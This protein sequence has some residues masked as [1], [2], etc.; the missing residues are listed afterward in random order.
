MLL[1][2]NKKK[3]SLFLWLNFFISLLISLFLIKPAFAFDV[4]SAP[5]VEAEVVASKVA[6]VAKLTQQIRYLEQALKTLTNA[7]YQWSMVQ[8]TINELGNAINQANTLAYNA[9]NLDARFK[10]IYP[11]YQSPKN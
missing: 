2:K 1:N 7:P 5:G 3:L 10:K 9:Q 6:E 8:N 11:G 4:V